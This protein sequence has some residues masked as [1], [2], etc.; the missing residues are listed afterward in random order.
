MEA[1]VQ[2]RGMSWVWPGS[3]DDRLYA[4]IWGKAGTYKALV[5]L[6]QVPYV[7]AVF[8]RFKAAVDLEE[9]H[10]CLFD[11]ESGLFVLYPEISGV[12]FFEASS[13][14]FRFNY[15][16]NPNPRRTIDLPCSVF[17]LQGVSV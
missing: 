9:M 15:I 17:W 2:A 1:Q 12:L 4:S 11:K 6:H 8:G 5:E 7:I 10:E 13:G 3:S 16:P 14:C